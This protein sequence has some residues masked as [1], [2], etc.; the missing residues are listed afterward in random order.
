MT[1]PL[2][3]GDSRI[4]LRFATGD[5]I[6]LI[7]D[8]VHQLATFVKLSDEVVADEEQLRKTLFGERQ[9][10][11]VVIASYDDEPAGFALFFHSYS[12]FLGQP[13]IYLEDLFVVPALRGRGIGRVLLSCLA[14]LAVN[15]EC[16][17]LEWAVID[18][19]EPAI[20]FYKRLGAE[21]LEDR[22]TYRLAG[23]ALEDLADLGD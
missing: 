8:F 16:G 7:L 19:N 17:R 20:R 14:R 15:R 2:V 3:T 18:W 21:A 1:D 23:G 12:T 6:G 9:T 5:D 11:E 13:G 4:D 10:A 22:R